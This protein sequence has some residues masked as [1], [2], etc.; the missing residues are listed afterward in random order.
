MR[1]SRL[2]SRGLTFYWRTNVAVVV[3]VATAAAVLA[4]AL[5]VGDSV[6]GSLRDLVLQRLGRADLAVLSSSFFREALADDVRSDKAFTASFEAIS[7]MVVLPALVTDQASGRRA[8]RVQVYGVD[9]RFW[10]FH[11]VSGRTGPPGRAALINRTLA[12]EIGAGGGSTVLVRVERPSSIPIES[13]HGR[14]DNVGRSIRLSVQ[15]VLDAREI[16]DFSLQP[17]QGPV[18]TIFVPLRRLQED[19]DVEGRVNALLVA[20]RQSDAATGPGQ[21]LRSLEELIRRR[22]A[23]QDVGLSVRAIALPP[24][25]GAASDR[26]RDGLAVESAAGLLDAPRAKAS[27]AAAA[28]AGM[29][30]QPILTYLANSLRSGDREVPYSLVTAMDLGMVAPNLRVDVMAVPPPIVLNTWAARDLGIHAGDAVSLDYYVWEEPGRLLT[31]TADFRVAAVIPIEGRAADRSLA[32]VYPGI[33]EARTLGDWDP[34]FPI[35]LKRVRRVDEDYWDQYRTTPKAFVPFEVGQRLWRSRFGDRTSVRLRPME[36]GPSAGNPASL[37]RFSSSLR[38]QLEP[39]ALGV[40]VRDV[41]AAGLAASRGATDFGEYFTYFSFFLVVSALMLAALFFRLGV[42]QRSREV[43]LL[44]SVGFSNARVRRLFLAEGSVLASFGGAFGLA[45]AI[46]YAAAMMAGLR[47][48][49]SGAVGTKALTLHVE[50]VSLAI[51]AA[52]SLASAIV[53]IW[54]TLGRLARLSERRLLAGDLGARAQTGAQRRLSIGRPGWSFPN[55]TVMFAVAFMVLAATLLAL[56]FAGTIDRT[57][58][59]FGAGTLLLIACLCAV[60]FVLSRPRRSSLH[61]HGWTSVWRI[62]LRNAADRPGRSMLAVGVIASATFILIAVA[63]FRRVDAGMLDRHSGTGGYPLLVDLLLPI[64]MD[65]NSRDGRELLGIP[66]ADHVSIEP[67]RVLPGDDASCLNLYEPQRPR[68]LGVRRTLI[69]SGRFAFQASLASSQSDRANPWLLLDRDLGS[70]IVP[71]AGDANS[72]TY[73]LHKQLGEDVV[74]AHGDRAVRLRLVA[75]LSDSIFQGELLMS[76]ANFTRLFPEQEGFRFLLVDAPAAGAGE[77]AKGIEEG[78]GD[79]GADAVSTAERLAEFHAVENTYL[80]TFQTLGG[81]GLL[82][83]TIGLAAVVLRNV[84]ERRR[85]LA[86]LAAVGYEWVHMF[87]IVVAENLL[88][89]A[90]G[91]AIGTACALIAITPAAAEH[92]GRLPVTSS[93]WLV[94]AVFAA[95]LLSSVIAT[96]AALRTPLL[97]ALRSE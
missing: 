65:P 5:L 46:G 45:G 77:I 58:G 37:D 87:V 78:A 13:L 21:A 4:G 1:A 83:G 93:G 94:V 32:P 42:E 9:D 28:D 43:G 67:F 85:E 90:W 68:I 74:I 49:W 56:S 96:R 62:G 38:A 44:R 60:R 66:N 39:L 63:A 79:F 73:V 50:P 34:P 22:F 40:T 2:V 55:A 27:E 3:G 57:G 47:G 84:L 48:W 17:Q 92:G 72:I 52:A 12:D 54:W 53:C 64:A 26:S 61:G 8:S 23:L 25:G 41:R 97:A 15:S 76:D 69:E 33:T 59:F 16:G 29:T 31:R 6:R 71:V 10:R 86:L 81:L 95:G 75:A 20:A 51:G 14:K 89:L 30:P 82:L 91:L 11:G 88:L 70:D 18:R 24:A 7:P 36:N 19:L 80:S 35:D